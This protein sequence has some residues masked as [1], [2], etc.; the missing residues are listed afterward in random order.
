[1]TRSG[2]NAASKGADRRAID[3]VLLLDKPAGITSH[4][5]VQTVR[6]LL[7]GAKAGHTGTLDPLATGLLPICLGEAT[8]FAHL[9]LDAEKRY[10]AG[11]R[12]GITTSTGDLEGEVTGRSPVSVGREDVDRVL[13]RFRGEIRQTPPMYSALKL[14]GMPLYKHAR[15]GREVHREP[16]KVTISELVLVEATADTLTLRVACSKGTYIR[17]LAEDIGRELGCGACLASLRREAVGGFEL[18]QAVGLDRLEETEPAGR[19]ALLLP[20]DSLVAGLPRLDLDAGDS[21]KLTRG[22]AVTL[23]EARIAGLARVYGP[24]QEFLGVAEVKGPGQLVA[25]R[26]RSQATAEGQK[27]GSI[28]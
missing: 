28:S 27:S 13:A 15:A 16:R 12:L 3:G 20:V 14:D 19:E 9:L 11:V 18:S 26:L 25:R 10:L 1:M 5:A 17:V 24:E 23:P 22:Q 8:K 21:R 6:R 7:G 2:R 4:R